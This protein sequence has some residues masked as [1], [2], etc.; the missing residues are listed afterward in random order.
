[1]EARVEGGACTVELDDWLR[2]V[3]GRPF[4]EL[5]FWSVVYTLTEVPGIERVALT[6]GGAPLK[7]LGDPPFAVPIVATRA[8]APVWARPRSTDAR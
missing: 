8:D 3:H 7:E 1:M 4:S 6:R 5:V 2:R